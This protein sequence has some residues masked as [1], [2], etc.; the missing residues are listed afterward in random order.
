M[1]MAAW[2]AERLIHMPR[3]KGRVRLIRLLLALSDG[4]TITTRYG[5]RMRIRAADST[6]QAAVA[7]TF[8][9]DYDDVYAEIAALEPGTAF[10][11][12]G[13]NHGLFTLVA[14]KRVGPEGMVL[15]FEPDLTNF[16]YLVGNVHANRLTNVIPFNAAISQA[17]G[18]ARFRP[19]PT[20]HSGI[21]SL[22]T[23]GPSRVAT[24]NFA[25]NM[26]LF[27]A[28]V[29]E[30]R[31]VIKIDVEGHEGQ[32]LN[33][34]ADLLQGSKIEK[35]I[36]EIDER[37]LNRHGSTVAELY[38]GLTAAGFQGLRGRGVARHYNEVFVRAAQTPSAG[39][40]SFLDTAEIA[41]Q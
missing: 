9:R 33:A 7:G 14:G 1:M 31:T 6:N 17:N 11:D 23:D 13:A 24:M 18:V 37:N 39:D 8:R 36:V 27:C 26:A 15:S 5:V 35:L 22:M 25:D 32:V 16:Q 38:D 12:I 3:F 41:A 29:G 10:I 28:L 20:T 21:G 30:R 34:L 40:P 2:L 4:E 19:G